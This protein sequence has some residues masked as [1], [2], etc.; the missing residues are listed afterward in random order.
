[1]TQVM[2]KE[3]KVTIGLFGIYMVLLTWIILFKMATSLEGLP[4]IRSVN[5]VPFGESVIVN[6]RVDVSEIWNNLLAFVPVGIYL[7]MLGG[8]RGFWKKAGIVLGISLGYEVLQFVFG[9]GASDV[10]DL[11]MNT[12]GGVVGIG[13][14]VLLERLLKGKTVLVLNVLA[15]MCTVLLV[16]LL[17]VLWAVN[18]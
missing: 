5:L 4:R 18:G 12:L 8:A 13:G 3:K 6:G 17:M 1:M 16:G 14:Y 7:G 15:G 11:L 9:I 2:E 10:T